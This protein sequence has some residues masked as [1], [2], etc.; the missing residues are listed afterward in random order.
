MASLQARHTRACAL[1]KPWAPFAASEGCT[2]RP[3]FYVVVREGPKLSRERV[4][5]SR[6]EAERA[7]TK[8]QAAEDDGSYQPVPNVRF[9]KWGLDWLDGLE[10]PSENTVN[11]YRPSVA[12]A[13][14][15]FGRKV[16]RK[17]SPSDVVAFLTL[18]REQKISDSTRAKHL[19]VLGACLEAAV[20]DGKAL[21]NPVR[22]LRPEAKPRPERKESAY[23]ENEE[24]PRLFAELAD[25]VH[26]VLLELALKTGMREGELV[27][28]TWGDV[29]L[30]EN[31]IHVRKSYT[32][33]RLGETKNRERRAV[34]LTEDL[35]E[36]LGEWWGQSG[37][38][39][40]DE[41]VFPRERSG[42]YVPHWVLT[43]QVLYPAMKR[44]GVEREGPTGQKRT[45]HSL[46]H[47]YAK[48]ALETGREITWLSKHL[49]HSSLKVTVDIYG[50]W[51]R[52]AAKQEA[53]KML[54][55]FGI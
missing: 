45:F 5:K 15:A 39:E 23:F 51:S 19:R 44:A 27:A 53:E 7:L 25:G 10:R 9:E 13:T 12:Y 41:L 24:L 17:L 31:Q 49:G 28:L 30:T 55:V 38:R 8:I 6:R 46:R 1:G 21:R 47:T 16:V 54:G 20:I 4:G 42:G 52:A 33:G 48:R 37:S 50:H 18:M 40:E 11:S 43:R 34:S 35:V 14:Q 26:R 36:L 22:Q 32:A 3:T 2:C 29:D